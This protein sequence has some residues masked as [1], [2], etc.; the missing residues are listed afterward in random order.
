MNKFTKILAC[1]LI[2][3]SL[4]GTLWADDSKIRFGKD[5]EKV[6]IDGTEYTLLEE[7][8]NGDFTIY[9]VQDGENIMVLPAN[10][11]SAGREG[12]FAEGNARPAALRVMMNLKSKTLPY[13]EEVRKNPNGW[14]VTDSIMP[15]GSMIT[16]Y[17]SSDTAFNRLEDEGEVEIRVFRTRNAELAEKLCGEPVIGLTR[18]QVYD[19]FGD[20][21][22]N[23][24]ST[25][26]YR[27]TAG[28]T[29]EIVCEFHLHN[30]VVTEILFGSPS[31]FDRF[32]GYFTSA[33]MPAGLLTPAVCKGDA[34]R[35]RKTPVDGE[36]LHKLNKYDELFIKEFQDSDDG[37]SVWVNIVTA[38]GRDGWM[39]G[40]YVSVGSTSSSQNACMTNAVRYIYWRQSEYRDE[41][42]HMVS[43]KEPGVKI[44][45]YEVGDSVESLESLKKAFNDCMWDMEGNGE[46]DP[47]GFNEWSDRFGQGTIDI[48]TSSGKIKA[49]VIRLL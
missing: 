27:F 21:P 36:P 34:V 47:N 3:G 16:F 1:S 39:H 29:Y 22:D 5:G 19:K 8:N 38:D 43:I 6:T 46:I 32:S 12:G 25:I 42:A 13:M 48:V 31:H 30:D 40:D 10:D 9:K 37:K 14:S 45:G 15:I 49:F 23:D 41:D 33:P 26:L 11:S 2:T 24:T 18:K 4:C 35:V 28:D 44:L 17:C 20:Q 7:D